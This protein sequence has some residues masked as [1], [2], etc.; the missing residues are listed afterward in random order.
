MYSSSNLFRKAY[1]YCSKKYDRIV[2]LSAKYGL[3]LPD[4]EIEAYNVT[5]NNMSMNEVEKWSESVFQM[6]LKIDLSD[7]CK[8]YFHAGKRYRQYLIPKIEGMRIRCETPLKNLSIGKQLSWYE[9]H[10]AKPSIR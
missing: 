10:V 5:L 3:L 8:V 4:E 2:I 6:K 9:K 1:A 7:I